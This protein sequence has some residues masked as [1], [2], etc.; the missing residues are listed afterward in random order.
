MGNLHRSVLH[1]WKTSFDSEYRSQEEETQR[2]LTEKRA[3]RAPVNDLRRVRHVFQ[4][5]L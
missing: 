5:L 4:G 3:T 1:I 2:A